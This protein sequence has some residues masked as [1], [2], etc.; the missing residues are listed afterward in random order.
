MHF[1]KAVSLLIVVGLGIAVGLAVMGRPAATSSRP[2]TA[3]L[4]IQMSAKSAFSAVVGTA[5]GGSANSL[6]E[7][8][9]LGDLDGRED[10]V[11]DHS[12]EIANATPTLVPGQ[13][14]TRFAISE[15]TI[16]NG[17]AENLFYYGDSRAM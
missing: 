3:G 4:G 12:L 16:A 13:T 8:A 2:L 15:H 17:F 5:I 9:L 1:K 7:I 10:L 14:L 6:N 11:A